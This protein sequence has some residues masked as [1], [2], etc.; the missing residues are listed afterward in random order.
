MIEV[1]PDSCTYCQACVDACPVPEC[2]ILGD[3]FIGIDPE[4]C[5]GCGACIEACPME[6]RHVADDS[7][8]FFAALK[9]GRKIAAVVAP[10][11]AAAFPDTYENL[12]GWL[13]SLGIASV[14]DVSFG[15][16]LTVK[17]YMDYLT[18][19]NP[20][21]VIA[22]PCPVIVNFIETQMP[23]LLPYLAP[24]D[25]PLGHTVKMIREY[26]PDLADAEIAFIS[27][28]AAK[29]QELHQTGCGTYNVTF[30]S[31]ERHLRTQG[32]DLK[33]FPALDYE[34]PPAERAV[35][36]STPGGLRATA[37]RWNPEVAEKTCKIEGVDK[38]FSFL[39][40]LPEALER[41]EAPMLV[42][43]LACEKGCNGGTATPARC[44]PQ[45][46]LERLIAA[47]QKKMADRYLHASPHAGEGSPDAAI[48][49]AIAP[50]VD[51]YWQPGL[52]IRTYEDR[53]PAGR[54][55][56]VLQKTGTE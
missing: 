5:I 33:S 42:D 18:T 55:A 32:I 28:C 1:D 4:R 49:D 31:I 24:V 39:R 13:L 50:V 34:S 3:S 22:Q 17:S 30:D 48:Q 45:A 27:P 40:G 19:H 6:A 46:E 53:S 52:Y 8:A 20:K 44:K 37:E 47:R 21:M 16:E 43:C 35:G 29:R 14:F 25:S 51:S 38:V 2:N 15:A 41:G 56:A 36:F 10:A 26:Y 23:E 9:D 11:I 54:E 12:N 7:R